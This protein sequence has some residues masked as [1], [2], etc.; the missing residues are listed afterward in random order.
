MQDVLGGGLAH[1][2]DETIVEDRS[3]LEIRRFWA[4]DDLDVLTWLDPARF[5]SG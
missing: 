5:G 1:T 3:R 4:T 2:T